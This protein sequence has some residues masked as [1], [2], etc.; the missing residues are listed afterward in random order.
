MEDE[1]STNAPPMSKKKQRT[2]TQMTPQQRETYDLGVF[3]TNCCKT[4][5][6][7]AAMRGYLEAKQRGIHPPKFSFNTLL[8]L[9]AGLGEQGSGSFPIR[10]EEPPSDIAAAFTVFND[11]KAVEAPIH[12]A[13][14]SGLIRCCSLNQRH[15]D[16]LALLR[17]MQSMGIT[18]RIRSYSALLAAYCACLDEPQSIILF[19]E[20]TDK[21]HLQPSEKDY[22]SMLQLFCTVDSTTRFYATLHSMM[23][24]ILVPSKD[25]W[26]VL[27]EWFTTRDRADKFHVATCLASETGVIEDLNYTL[28]PVELSPENKAKLLA[29]IE[30]SICGEGGPAPRKRKHKVITPAVPVPAADVDDHLMENGSSD[31]DPGP[32]AD[33]CNGNGRSGNSMDKKDQEQKKEKVFVEPRDKWATFK[34][35]IGERCRHADECPGSAIPDA[36]ATGAVT[37]TADAGTDSATASATDVDVVADEDTHPAPLPSSCD[38]AAVAEDE[39]CIPVPKPIR[40][41]YVDVVVDGANVGYYQQ[42]FENA[43]GYI[44][45]FQL[46]AMVRH[47]ISIGR[48]P[49]LILH[50]RH[51]FNS[52]M[53]EDYKRVIKSWRRKNILYVSPSGCNDDTFWLYLTVLLGCDVVTNDEMRD[54]HF[55]ML[56]PR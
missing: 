22:M 40:M 14:Y 15:V 10:T 43:S 39:E 24:D 27:T 4:M 41:Q 20:L 54:H 42:N 3:L 37:I 47:L 6:L 25:L 13:A 50:C 1:I 49:L 52:F 44:D 28:R 19:E 16:G 11:A 17:E 36:D 2:L 51:I 23:E 56:S 29:Q 5:D 38:D 48:R 33:A 9:A 35:W 55:Q 8:A 12:E 30:Q 7:D 21:Y 46:D 32:A 53:P 45:Y 31:L 26:T 34:K 18:P